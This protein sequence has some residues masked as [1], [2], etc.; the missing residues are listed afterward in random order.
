MR[1]YC[2][3][4]LMSS[5]LIMNGHMFQLTNDH[6]GIGVRPASADAES[7]QHEQMC[8]KPIS[9]QCRQQHHGKEAR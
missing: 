5:F 1:I 8:V 4:V 9:G 7:N 6:K 2:P 3:V